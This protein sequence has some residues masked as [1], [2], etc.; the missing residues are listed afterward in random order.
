MTVLEH[1]VDIK[2]TEQ[3][4]DEIV[5]TLIITDNPWRLYEIIDRFFKK[6]SNINR[7]SLAEIQNTQIEEIAVNLWNW[8]VTKRIGLSVSESQAAKLCHVAC[9]LVYMYGISV[10]SEEAIQRQILMNMKT[11]RGWLDTGNAPIADEF[12]QAAMA[13]LEKLYVKLVQSCY[14][15]ADLIMHKITVEKGIFR[16]LSYQAES[17]VAQG[18]FQKASMCALRCK[19]MLMRFPEMT[20]YLHVLC[21]N[22]G[23]ETGKQNKYKESSFWLRQSYEIGKMDKDSVE[24]EMLAKVLRLLATVYLECDDKGYYN[25]ALIAILL[26]NKEHLD[27]AGLFLKMR[28]L[29]KG[30]TCNEELLEAVMEIIHLAMPLEFCLNITQLLIDNKRDSVGFRFLRIIHGHFKLAEDSK[31]IVLFYIDML[32]QKDQDL[33]AKEKIEEILIDH[34][35]RN[36]LTRDLVNWLH[37]ILWV[38]AARSFKVQ[39]YTDALHWYSYSM[40][41]YECDQ[42]DLDLVKLKRNMASC[43]LHLKQLDKAKE[44]ITEAEQ[45]DPTNILTQFYI[46]KIAIM[47]GN[48]DRALQVVSTLTKLLTNEELDDDGLLKSEV[49][50]TKII[51]LAIQFA[52]ENGQQFVA[53]KALEYLS[54]F[55]EDPKEVLGALKCL[56]RITLPQVSQMPEFENKK[57]EMDKLLTYLN[58]ALLKFSQHFDEDTS[59]LDSRVNDANWFRKI[60]WNLALQSEKDLE[61]MKNFFMVSYKLSLF[62][63]SDQGLLIAQKA[64]LLVAAAVDLEQGRKATTTSEQTRLLRMSLEQTQKCKVVWNL[65]KQ[66]GDF[67][68]DDCETILLL[69][70]FEAKTKMNDPSLYSFLDSVWKMSDLESRTLE[71]MALLAMEKPAHYPIIA[72]KALKKLLLIHGKKEPI[73]VLKYSQCMHNLIDLL[74]SD[75]VSSIVPYSL[76][77]I[78]SH[79]KNALS[80]ISQTEGYP[81]EEILWL[82]IKSWNIGIVMYSRNKYVC[83]ERWAGLA[84]DF[85]GHLGSLKINYEAKV[86]LLYVNLMEALDKRWELRSAE[87]AERLKALAAAP[88]D[89]GLVPSIQ[90]AA[91]NHL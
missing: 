28:I 59:S 88:E 2:V 12:F 1:V 6:I 61:T 44:A 56:V 27:P 19:D 78:W 18:D 41:L 51:S 11:G 81:E 84:V 75:G 85:L 86:N 66:T 20:G 63:P 39:N 5:R 80:L 50:P 16:V 9:K 65:L 13:D 48:S 32:L 71:T 4:N 35:T 70:E 42:E 14:T 22:L 60:A 15:E 29:M 30:K 55:S 33:I 54:Q 83:A 79:L 89:P 49:S 73:D 17:A 25:K 10:S 53:G 76:K 26:A 64:C 37:S 47:E 74:V 38:K 72:Q 90:T 21:Y 82:M 34:Q 7:E 24:P 52:L 68:G 3:L 91:P 23:V 62:C 8:T 69:Y 46:F 36:Q 43:Y 77:E 58:T 40:K 67:A 45:Q 57:K 31:K 87:M